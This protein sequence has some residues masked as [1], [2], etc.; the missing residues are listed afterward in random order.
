MVRKRLLLV[1][2]HPNF[3][4]IVGLMLRDEFEVVTAVDGADAVRKATEHH[5]DLILMDL[6]MP[7]MDGLQAIAALRQEPTT[8]EIPVLV[9]TARSDSAS[10]RAAR[11]AGCM[12]VVVKPFE[13]VQLLEKV[14]A[15]L[16]R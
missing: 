15:L 10:E 11:D 5:P 14:R 1:D 3:L 7:V 13:K 2:D 9:V 16:D 12:D 8:R 6:M 4:V